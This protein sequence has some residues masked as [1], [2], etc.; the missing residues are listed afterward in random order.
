MRKAVHSC[1]YSNKKIR[2]SVFFVVTLIYFM[3]MNK[4]LNEFFG[5]TSL[6]YKITH[7]APSKNLSK[8]SYQIYLGLLQ[9]VYEM[10]QKRLNQLLNLNRFSP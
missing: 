2:A 7:Y 3:E 9:Q 10:A 6:R 5:V 1:A 8:G 4:R